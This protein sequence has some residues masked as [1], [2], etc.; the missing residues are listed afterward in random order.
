[1]SPK[2]GY[3]R[4]C[5][6]AFHSFTRDARLSIVIWQLCE[7]FLKTEHTK[8]VFQTKGICPVRIDI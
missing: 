4:R 7:P 5:D 8:A 2:K 1:M 3:H 6:D